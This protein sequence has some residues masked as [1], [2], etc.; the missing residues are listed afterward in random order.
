MIKAPILFDGQIAPDDRTEGGAPREGTLV[1]AL[2]RVSS[3][4][5]QGLGFRVLLFFLLCVHVKI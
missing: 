4:K 2:R 1:G 5:V 3:F